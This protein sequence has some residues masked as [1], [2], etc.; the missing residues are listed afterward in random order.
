MNLRN[1]ATKSSG[2]TACLFTVLKV[3]QCLCGSNLNDRRFKCQACPCRALSIVFFLLSE[4]SKFAFSLKM[5]R[6]T[7]TSHQKNFLFFFIKHLHAMTNGS[8]CGSFHFT[9]A[10]RT[11]KQTPNHQQSPP[12]GSAFCESHRKRV[13]YLCSRSSQPGSAWRG[14][15]PVSPTRTCKPA[16]YMISI[17][18][19]RSKHVICTGCE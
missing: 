7:L 1:H 3:I 16:H 14:L 6:T 9:L 17:C 19:L 4:R 15:A 8:V 2:K 11:G 18:S 10:L 5:C 13:T 12:Q